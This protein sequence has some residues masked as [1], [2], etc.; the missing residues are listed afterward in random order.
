MLARIVRVFWA[1]AVA[2]WF[3]RFIFFLFVCVCVCVLGFIR[4]AASD[5]YA[6]LYQAF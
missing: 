1:A 2:T 6:G 5:G 4:F 3:G